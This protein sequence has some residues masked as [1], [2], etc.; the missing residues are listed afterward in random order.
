[1]LVLLCFITDVGFFVFVSSGWFWRFVSLRSFY[2][3][4]V[5]VVAVFVWLK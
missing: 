1:M 4:F 3:V 2:C 5:W